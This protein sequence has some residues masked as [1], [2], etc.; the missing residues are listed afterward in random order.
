MMALTSHHSEVMLIILLERLQSAFQLSL[1]EE[2]GRFRKDGTHQI[3]A[4]R[5]LNAK[6][7]GF[8]Y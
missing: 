5:L 3:L 1:S 6:Q 8:R 4:L 7:C 2:Q